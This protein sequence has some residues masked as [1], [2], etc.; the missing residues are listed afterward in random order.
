M[1]GTCRQP[2]ALARLARHARPTRHATL[3]IAVA[4]GMLAACGGGT[5]PPPASPGDAASPSV[6]PPSGAPPNFVAIYAAAELSS[7]SEQGAGFTARV[8]ELGGTAQVLDARR[9]PRRTLELAREALAAGARGIAVSAPDAGIGPEVARLAAEAGAALVATDTPL[10]DATGTPVPFT[11]FDDA[12]MGATVGSTAADLLRASRWDPRAVGVLSLEVRAVAACN[13][14]TDAEK[15]ALLAA[16]VPS[17]QVLA[18]QYDGS[19]RS[20]ADAA[21]VVAVGNPQLTRWIAVGCNDEGVQGALDALAIAEIEMVDVVGVGLG[22]NLACRAW[23][24]G[25]PTA[26]RASLYA[27]PLEVGSSAAGLLWDAAIRGTP[28]PPRTLAP[29]AMVTAETY[30]EV[31]APAFADACAAAVPGG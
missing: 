30:Q 10:A 25:A 11:G 14:R 18:V 4:V 2:L 9:D 26:F 24:R 23:A 15:Q 13:E 5:S 8:A 7:A 21:L 20:A 28:L 1:R 29:T 3:A 17:A 31:V 16:G 6:A 19:V 12:A 27:A 22:A